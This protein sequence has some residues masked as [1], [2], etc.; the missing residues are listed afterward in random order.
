MK[1][2]IDTHAME[3]AKAQTQQSTLYNNYTMALM[4]QI[5]KIQNEMH[6]LAPAQNIQMPFANMNHL[7]Q[8]KMMHNQQMSN[9]I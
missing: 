4:S 9:N 1:A 3:Q 7:Q 2:I 8:L 5:S 6:P